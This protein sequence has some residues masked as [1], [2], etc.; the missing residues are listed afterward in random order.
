MDKYRIPE[1]KP[2]ELAKNLDM[3]GPAKIAERVGVSRTLVNKWR[4][5]FEDFPQPLVELTM[6]PLWRWGDVDSWIRTRQAKG[7]GQPS[8]KG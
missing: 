2:G 3:V 4:E 6:G 5:R 7:L 8:S 1:L